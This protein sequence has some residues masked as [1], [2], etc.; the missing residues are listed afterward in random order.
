MNESEDRGDH[1]TSEDRSDHK[2]YC[3]KKSGTLLE[4]TG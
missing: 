2:A 3:K 1:K 4:K